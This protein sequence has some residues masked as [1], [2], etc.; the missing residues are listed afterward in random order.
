MT[1]IHGAEEAV[2]Y[3]RAL[4]IL[5]EY[6]CSLPSTYMVAL[7]TATVPGD[8]TYWPPEHCLTVVH[9]IIYMHTKHPY[10]K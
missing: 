5:P 10:T 6:P 1:A 8:P 3:F 9:C 4:V 2:Q 7:T